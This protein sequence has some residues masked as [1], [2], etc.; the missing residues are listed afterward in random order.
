MGLNAKYALK[1]LLPPIAVSAARSLLRTGRRG[2]PEW[3][4]VPT[5][6]S[7]GQRKGWN[8]RSIAEA[9]KARWPGFVRGLEGPG[10]LGVAHESPSSTRED[11]AAHNTI[12]CYAYALMLTA[13]KKDSL[14]I[15]DWGGGIGHYY[16][17]SKALLPDVNIEYSCYDLPLL[18]QLGREL[19]P[20]LSYYDKMDDALRKRYD[21]VLVSSSLQYFENWSEIVRKL[22]EVT[23]LFLYVTRLPIVQHASSF[24]VLQRP[25]RYGYESEYLGWFLNREEF[26]RCTEQTG[27]RL[28]REFLLQER[29]SVRGA[30]E[31]GESRGFLFSR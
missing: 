26:I 8:E 6:W 9:Q 4:Y 23:G 30:P 24:V 19:M 21:L 16:A 14:T 20:E 11:W 5:G 28:I 31:Q 3:E 10:P 15:L 25:Y 1:Q 17:I 7:G 29:P 18:C 12:M 13:R 22:A 27:M 2:L